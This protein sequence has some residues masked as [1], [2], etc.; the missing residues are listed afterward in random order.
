MVAA[1][2]W[3]SVTPAPPK[4]DFAQSD[5]LGHFIAYGALML[6]FAQ[7]YR[8]TTRLLYAAGFIAMGIGLEF[9]QGALGYRT[10]DT[11]DMYANALGVLLGWAIALVLPRVLP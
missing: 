8:G 4:V 5:K 2:V 10:F 7:L 6:W 1:V 9:V 11:L 3:L